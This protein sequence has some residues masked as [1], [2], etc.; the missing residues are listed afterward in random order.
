MLLFSFYDYQGS[1]RK[2]FAS[3]RR[4]VF[5]SG[6]EHESSA[7]ETLLQWSIMIEVG[8]EAELPRPQIAR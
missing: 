4:I 7:F 8:S 1:N 3:L 5:F 2:F 6:I